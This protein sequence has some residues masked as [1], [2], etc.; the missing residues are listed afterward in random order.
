LSSNQIHLFISLSQSLSNLSLTLSNYSKQKNNFYKKIKKWKAPVIS[1]KVWSMVRVV[2]FMLRKGISKGKLM[3]GLN[4][5]LKRH[6]KLAGK[7]IANLMFH[8]HSHHNNSCSTS[9][10][11]E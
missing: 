2:F 4:M 1:K 7:A 5:M 6:G 10:W 9:R 11:F 3:M 8:H